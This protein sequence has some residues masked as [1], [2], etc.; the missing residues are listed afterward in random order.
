MPGKVSSRSSRTSASGSRKSTTAEPSSRRSAT[1]KSSAPYVE[2]PEETPDNELRT[3]VSSIFRDSQRNT[4]SHRKL[5]VNLR[6]IQEACCYEPTSKKNKTGAEDFDEEEFT[7]EFTRCVLRVMPIK[8]SESVGEKAIRFIGLFLRHANEK[9]NEVTPAN[10]EEDGVLVETPSTRLTSH[11]MSTILPLLTAKE[12]FVRFRSTQLIS[13]II[14]SLD[15]IDDDLFQQLRHGLLRRIHDKE[16]MV[17]VQAVLGLGRLAG[18]EAEGDADESDDES[19]GGLLVKLLAVLQNDPS[20]DVRRSLL[21]NLPILPNTLPYLLERARDQD[22]ATRR[23]LYS[24]L[25]PALGDFRHLSLSMREKLLRW[26]LRDRDENVRKAAGR[27]FRERWI[28]DCLASA[29]AESAEGEVAEE[30]K[31]PNMDA[32]L[33]LLER[34]DVVNSGVENGVALEAMKGF[35]EGRPDFRDAVTFDDHFWDTL[36]AEAVFMARSFN[37]FCRNDGNSKYEALIEEKMPEVTKLAFY[38]QRYTAVLVEALKRIATQEEITEDVA[39]EEDTVEQ[40]FIV[41]QLLHIARTLDYSDEVG[42]RKMFTLLRQHLAIPDLPEEVTKLT[43]EV[44]RGICAATPAG[45]KEFCSVVLEAVADVH[46]TVMDEQDFEDAE[47]SFHSARSDVSDDEKPTRGKKKPPMTEEEEQEK[48]VREIMVNMKCLHIV[49][50]MLENVEGS[51]K[52]NADLVAMLNNLVVPAVR[53]HEAPVRERGLLCIGLC[54]LLDKSLAEE[55][56]AL[57]IHFF[58]KGHSALQITAL[59]ILT[60]MLNQHGAQLLES[61]PTILTKVYLKALKAGAKDPEVQA[62]A[63]VAVAKL[64]LG[65]VITDS[66]SAIDDLLKTLVVL[67]FDP[68]TAHNQG[69]RQT[70][71]YFLPVYCYSR[72]ENQD[73]MRGVALDAMHKLF[74]TQ[75]DDEDAEAEMVG[76]GT[77]GAHLVDWTDPRKCYVPGNQLTLSDDAAKKAVNGDVHLDF[78][79]DILERLNS[80]MRLEE[81]KTLT[82][83]LA[84]LHISPASS[85]DKL[86]ATYEEVTEAVENKKLGLDATGRNALFKIHVTLGKIVNS[87][88][89]KDTREESVLRGGSVMRDSVRGESVPLGDS[90]RSRAGSVESKKSR[91]PE[92]IMDNRIKMESVEEDVEENAEGEDVNESEGT[93]VADQEKTIVPPDEEESL[94]EQQL[95]DSLVESLLD[96]DGD[97]EM[98]AAIEYSF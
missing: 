92:V 61:N 23:A 85:E 51:L 75:D 10:E 46:D 86:R 95:Q 14:N 29:A 32:L 35:W 72:T 62:A 27:L 74:E 68:S 37:D 57:F 39:E 31:A 11:L 59:Q 78:A 19:S 71:T 87:L 80:S 38:L 6:K 90:N 22:P 15:S 20:A 45:E 50:C 64:L 96:D 41:E 94:L 2:I 47:E 30:N 58:S 89:E 77:I 93:V 36:S 8:K 91:G 1:S 56:L 5:V 55:N 18:N 26:G 17:R 12:K 84:K 24:R 65:R 28:E 21:I 13:H 76:L 7:Y 73:R 53:S 3:Q 16:A 63:T 49:Q 44:L 69:V 81:K 98:G 82:P 88:A 33:E 70:L 9:D 48:A 52:E 60:D 43:V 83:L 4:A 25:L 97:I 34:I 67:Y 66:S 79:M 54:S 42:R 40:E